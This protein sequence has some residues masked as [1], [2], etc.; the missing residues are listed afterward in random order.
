MKMDLFRKRR[1]LRTALYLNLI[2]RGYKYVWCTD[3]GDR[4]EYMGDMAT[5]TEVVKWYEWC[6][7]QQRRS[8]WSI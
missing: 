3:D 2:V 6:E 7:R 4:D 1:L 8:G 5:M